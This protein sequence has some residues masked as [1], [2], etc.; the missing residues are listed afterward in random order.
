YQAGG[1]IEYLGRR[2]HQVKV[3][4]FRIELGEVEAALRQYPGVL[5]A[6]ADVKEVGGEKRLLAYVV[7][8]TTGE[9]VETSSALRDHLRDCLPDFMVPA[10]V[11]VL[12]KMPMTPN[13]KLDRSSLP[14]PDGLRPDLPVAFAAPE[15]ETEMIV[16]SIW[17]EVLRLD[18][19]GIDDNFFDLG[20]HS[21]QMIQVHARIRQ[22]FSRDMSMVQFFQYP[23]IRSLARHLSSNETGTLGHQQGRERGE[24][25][26]AMTGR[27]AAA[28]RKGLR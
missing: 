24:T 10:A 22:T 15:S 3:R 25:R 14:D 9:M 26:L 2:D 20:G 6:V 19:V 11:V 21:L 18:Q 5:D 1:Q 8:L 16:A 17:R 28:L 4:G 23:S 12:D 13:G 7:V 27:R